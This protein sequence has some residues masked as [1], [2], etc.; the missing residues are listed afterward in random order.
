MTFAWRLLLQVAVTLISGSNDEAA[1]RSS[2]NRSYYAALG[3]AREFSIKNGLVMNKKKASHEQVWQYL[4]GGGSENLAYRRAAFKAIGDIGV[5][6][7][8]MRVQADYKLGS[9]PSHSD[10][11][12]AASLARRLVQ[13]IHS[14]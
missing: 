1:S 11:Q 5:A 4:R 2:I 12:Q 8:A 9:P 7:R 13:R 3:E 6:L 10:A 14:L